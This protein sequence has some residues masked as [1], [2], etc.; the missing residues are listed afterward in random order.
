MDRRLAGRES[1][2][3]HFSRL[4]RPLHTYDAVLALYSFNSM[5]FSKK[6]N[7]QATS[8]KKFSTTIEVSSMREAT[9]SRALGAGPSIST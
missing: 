6:C 4:R 2:E 5:R 1:P 7:A 3:S 8:A 9:E